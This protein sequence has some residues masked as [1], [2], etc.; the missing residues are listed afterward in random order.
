MFT[1]DKGAARSI[2]CLHE[3]LRGNYSIHVSDF[4]AFEKGEDVMCSMEIVIH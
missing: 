4:E 1:V 2:M 3:G